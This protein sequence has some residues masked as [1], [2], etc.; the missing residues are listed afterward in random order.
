MHL[1]E[2]PDQVQPETQAALGA[3][4]RVAHLGEEVEDP[5]QHLGRDAHAVVADPEDHIG[6]LD[7]DREADLAAVLGVLGRIVQQVG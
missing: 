3:V 2:A 6:S 7:R 5:G 4:Q 1:G